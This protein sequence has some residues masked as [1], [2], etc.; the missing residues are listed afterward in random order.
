MTAAIGL[1]RPGDRL[2]SM[3]IT[4]PI[5]VPWLAWATTYSHPSFLRAVWLIIVGSQGG[6]KVSSTATAAMFG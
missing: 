1:S 4:S 3:D 2:G 5:P 6:S